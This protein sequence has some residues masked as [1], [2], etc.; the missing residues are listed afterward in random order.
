MTLV[1]QG[2]RLERLATGGIWSEGPVYLPGEDALLWSDVRANH[3]RRWSRRDGAS[4]WRD[5]SDHT[6]GNTLDREGRVLHCCHGARAVLRTEP[7]G[8]LITVVDR[9]E[10]KRLNSP[11]DAV[12]ASD[13]AIWFTDPPY[14]IVFPEE[15]HP[16]ESEI[17]AN[18]VYRL[19]PATGEL[20]VVIEDMEAPNGLAFSPD[21]TT[22]YVADT[23]ETLPD[24]QEGAH[25]IRAWDVREG[26]RLSGGEVF[27]EIRPGVPDGLRVDE[28]GNV[29]TSSG[30]GV[31][32]LSPAG[33][34]LA[35]VPVPEVVAN[36]CFGGPD[37]R[38]LFITASTSLYA[39]EVAVR[40]ATAT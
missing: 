27:A 31:R 20:D 38:T 2:A 16:G 17:G 21:E 6:N 39:I 35:H 25:H 11:N 9:Y 22:L 19:D 3:M 1:P 23:G 33:S 32:V 30:D 28:H 24:R 14:G 37:G 34:E 13:G 26:R 36:C 5:P 18:L 7:D 15:G 40:G 12:V 10:G 4:V 29:W 8:T